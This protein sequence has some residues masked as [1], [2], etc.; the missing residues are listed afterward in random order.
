MT[1]CVFVS[2][3]STSSAQLT[4]RFFPTGLFPPSLLSNQNVNLKWIFT[5]IYKHQFEEVIFEWVSHWKVFCLKLVKLPIPRMSK[6]FG[7]LKVENSLWE[8]KGR[9]NVDEV[10]IVELVVLSKEVHVSCNLWRSGS[11][12]SEGEVGLKNRFIASVVQNCPGFYL[13][14]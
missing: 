13:C 12:H 6:L 10:L 9:S 1:L 7:K 5:Y 3:S 2:T 14:V 11:L 4:A 8:C